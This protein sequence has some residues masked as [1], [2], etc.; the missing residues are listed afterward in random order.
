MNEIIEFGGGRDAKEYAMG[1][2]LKDGEARV[3]W[4][5]GRKWRV[6]PKGHAAVIER[7]VRF[8][9]DCASCRHIGLHPNHEG[10]ALCRNKTSVAAGGKKAHCTCEACF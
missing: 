4:T 3:V 6:A 9:T 2:A 1:A 8:D 5:V 7:E 10:S